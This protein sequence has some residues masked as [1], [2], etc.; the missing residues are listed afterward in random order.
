MRAAVLEQFGSPLVLSEIPIPSAGP[1]RVLVRVQASGVNPLDTKIRAG[2]A[3]HAQSRL[4]AVLGLDLAGVVEQVGTGVTGFA[5][6]DQVYGL[7][8][9]VGTLQGSLAEY[10]AVDARLLAH[11]PAALSPRQAAALPLAA[12]T[13]WEGLVDRARVHEGQKVLVHGGA[14]GIGH[15]A[16][17]LALARGAQVYATGSA[18]SLETIEQLGATPI[19]YTATTPEEYLARHT[20]GEGFDIVFDTVGG[21]TLEA[22]F[23]AVRVHTGHVVS[24]LGWGNP[25]IAPLSFRGATY[26]GIFALLPML[27]GEGRTHHGEILAAAAPLV[28]S[29][30]LTPRVDPRRFDLSSVGDAHDAVEQG[31]AAGKIVIDIAE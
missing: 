28:D 21:A 24:A 30:T 12:I 3:A 17:Q 10:A 6:G 5:P 31:A 20:D 19:D 2:K 7:T 22:S 14:G 1:G 11:R 26:S 16:V 4:P 23:T 27:T 13:A 9:G 29:G 25:S 15:I 8:G 18:R